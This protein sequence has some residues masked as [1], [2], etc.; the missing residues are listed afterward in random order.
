M[1]I[2]VETAVWAWTEG[3]MKETASPEGA[4]LPIREVEE[5]LNQAYRRGFTEGLEEAIHLIQRE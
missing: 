5:L 1:T 4:Y 2:V 3:G